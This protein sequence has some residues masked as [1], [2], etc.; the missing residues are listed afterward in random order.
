MQN[1]LENLKCPISLEFFKDPVTIPTCGHTF[2]RLQLAQCLDS[3][4]DRICPFCKQDVGDFDPIGAPKNFTIA[5]LVE[6]YLKKQ[7]PEGEQRWSASLVPLHDR[8]GSQLPIGQLKV[9][10]EDSNF[11]AKPSL[12]IGVV[13]Q[14]GS[15]AGSA[16]RQVQTALLHID[17]LTRSNPLVKTV[18]ITY[19]SHAQILNTNGS[20]Q[21]VRQRIMATHA[22]GGTIFRGAFEQV[23]DVLS[24]Y[25]CSNDPEMAN[26]EN[27]ISNVTIGF[28]TDGQDNTLWQSQDKDAARAALVSDFKDMLAE[29][30][31][32]PVSV[33]AV[34]FSGSCDKDLL[35]M[36]R[37]AGNIEGMFR[38]A[39]PS[40]GDEA[41]C[42]KLQGLFDVAA[43][44]SAVGVNMKLDT[45][46]FLVG[47]L[48]NPELD[49]QFPISKN[50]KG[51][52]SQWVTVQDWNALGTLTINS[53]LDQDVVLE[54]ELHEPNESKRASLFN[55]WVAKLIDGAAS[56]LMD[57]A[58][59]P[60]EG[61]GNPFDLHCALIEQR[62][63]AMSL[64]TDKE[65]LQ[66]R[67]ASLSQTVNDLRSGNAVNMGKLGDLR[68]GSQ[69]AVVKKSTPQVA[70]YQPPPKPKPLKI[71]AEPEFTE[72]SIRYTRNPERG[73]RNALQRL[74]IS[75]NS[76]RINGQI[77]K[78]ID[79]AT[80]DDILHV[81]DDE[82]NTIHLTALSG[83]NFIMEA[84]LNKFPDV[85]VNK[86]NKDD[87]TPMT[88]AIKQR[89][90]WKVMKVLLKFGAE[91]P[92]G[93]KEALQK[94]AINSGFVVTG[95]MLSGVGESAKSVS[96]NQTPE[97]IEFFFETAMEKELEIDVESYLE[98]ALHHCMSRLV[99]T[100]L[101]DF[102]AVPT[103]D[104]LV[105][106][107]IPPKPDHPEVN[108]YLDLAKLVLNNQPRLINE[109]N[110]DGESALFKACEKGNLPHVKYFLNKGALVD[111]PNN[112]GNTPLWVSC[113]K[114][115][116]CI[117]QEL[118]N[119]GADVNAVN[120]KGNPPLYAVC[121]MGP[122]KV[123]ETL[124]AYGAT[125]EHINKNGDTLILI[126]CRNGQ[127]E[128]LEFLLNYVDPDFVNF[129]A[130]I[131]G[132]NAILAST[133][134]NRPDCIRVLHEY[135]INLEQKT[136][137]D[138]EIIAGAT[139][140]HLAA[141]Y[142][143][144]EAA[145]A[146]L[147]L[148]ANPNAVDVH[149]Q[150]P[151]HTAVIQGNIPIIKLLRNSGA[152]ITVQDNNGNTP[153]SYCRNRHEIRRVLVNPALDVLMRFA[154]G[155]FTKQEEKVGIEILDN[156]A[157]VLGCLEPKDAIEVIGN[158][159]ST[160]LM[161]AVINSNFD[162]VATLLK[163]GAD[164][165]IRNS[166]GLS[167]FL[168]ANWISNPRVK[169]VLSQYEDTDPEGT[170]E[171]IERLKQA[172]K[173]NPKD[174]FILFLGNKPKGM[175]I[176]LS[177]GIDQRMEEFVNTITLSPE[178]V[179]AYEK[180]ILTLEDSDE[181]PDNSRSIIQV[182][183]KEKKED[184]PNY[185]GLL[186]NAKVFIVGLIAS[187]QSTLTPQ[188]ALALCL[189]TNN[190]IVPSSVN[191]SILT[192]NLGSWKTYIKCLHSALDDM[193]P[194]EVEVYMGSNSVDRSLYQV[195]EEITRPTFTTAS[196]MWRVAIDH[197]TEFETKKKGTVFI[198]KSKT[199]RYVGQ[200]SQFCDAEILFK[201]NTR[202]RVSNW[203]RG[204]VI[205]LGQANIREHTFKIKEEDIPTYL[206][207]N[208]SLI[209][210]LE[211]I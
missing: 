154:K 96:K 80:L 82:N 124:I 166:L 133:E 182:F 210:E 3:N 31:N 202:F 187:G 62:L 143:R 39:E 27:N 92:A 83:Q 65:H 181:T 73:N 29:N 60:Q 208:K 98:A 36:M 35:E 76:N 194:F 79:S 151:L 177:S 150:T 14:S 121:Q 56:E 115:Y 158:D 131:D 164:P 110:D 102:G 53:H 138:N 8:K 118:L 49:V 156:Y 46:D 23:K 197:V 32:G 204:D 116:P 40:D 199:G 86:Q 67:I 146:L 170:Q 107:C 33:H 51:Q 155:G 136:D 200:F 162:L 141:Y 103:F 188:Q 148:G 72:H 112:M 19:Q 186:W 169:K 10:L 189:Y 168:W 139:S 15:M 42:Q 78:A 71:K 47:T 203:Y 37:K 205:C 159:G 129:K 125:V 61:R 195:G 196:T 50:R 160:P 128:I 41:L 105:E 12:F 34:G 198:V 142:N 174:A 1:T 68:F 149:G 28:L 206:G 119:W 192:R 163:M 134:A 9:N 43:K 69:F 201:P 193:P 123:A 20:A 17:G 13:D 152:D 75:H 109:K 55:K 54:I 132:F 113:A 209:I 87:E 172:R 145:Q 85:D 26:V 184:G 127:H 173:S 178:V 25:I 135:G 99:K 183:S 22:G 21:E 144:L 171:G 97:E 74:I 207:S 5:G 58:S 89:G 63:D 101:K 91:I 66:E 117:I 45:T 122:K 94:F 95:K 161:Q 176:L 114:R 24:N 88:I 175:T 64:C 6:D 93:R 130:H 18:I 165:N 59:Q 140:L 211:E 153:A 90:F 4:P 120:E 126:C 84:L 7:E 147:S 137:D 100:L 16:W 2:D 180:E 108:K 104:M 167:S 44:S 30:W 57:L 191:K 185:E 81:D 48:V 77:Q 179:E 38:Y 70:G 157:G 11:S 111:D 52:Y 106:Y 190:E